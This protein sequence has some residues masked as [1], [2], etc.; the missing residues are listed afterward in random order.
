MRRIWARR[1]YG[2]PVII[3]APRAWLNGYYIEQGPGSESF[4]IAANGRCLRFGFSPQAGIRI[5][6]E[7]LEGWALADIDCQDIE[8]LH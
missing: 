2:L 6:E 4:D 3:H 8:V 7:P 5:I 1:R